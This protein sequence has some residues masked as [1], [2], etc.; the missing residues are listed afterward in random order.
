M[1]HQNRRSIYCSVSPWTPTSSCFLGWIIIS[2]PSRGMAPKST[3]WAPGTTMALHEAARATKKTSRAHALCAVFLRHIF[4]IAETLRVSL[5]QPQ[6]RRI[7]M[8]VKRSKNCF[9]KL[10]N[11][12]HK[13]IS[14][15]IFKI[16]CTIEPI[17]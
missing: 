14:P 12:I 11:N 15:Q 13:E 16:Q 7:P 5:S 2:I 17:L 3:V 10:N 4:V 9:Y 8:H 1:V 6:K